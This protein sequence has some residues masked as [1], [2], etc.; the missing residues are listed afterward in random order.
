MS[1]YLT[2]VNNC[3]RNL[4][5][6]TD[7]R[8]PVDY[9]KEWINNTYVDFITRSKFP[10]LGVS[11]P[12]K[13]PEL[14]DTSTFVTA[15]DDYDYDMPAQVMF[16]IGM[17]DT[18]NDQPLRQRDIHWLNRNRTTTSSK[19]LVYVTFKK[20]EALEI[21]H[22][23]G[24][25][26]LKNGNPA[27]HAHGVFADINGQTIGGHVL[28]ETVV[29]GAEIYIQELLGDPPAREYDEQTGLLL[30]N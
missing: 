16:L 5:G 18:T 1:T 25:V 9:L 20:E 21:V 15:A 27:V 24:N 14:E 3:I 23:T 26:S 8:S 28:S 29:Y 4:G 13:I 22:C 17:R 6:R 2:I 19:P 30:W 11:A 7:L 12:L 10:E